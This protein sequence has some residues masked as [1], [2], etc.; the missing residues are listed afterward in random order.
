MQG[1]VDR[2][3]KSILREVKPLTLDE[4]APEEE[5]KAEKKKAAKKAL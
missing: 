1:V 2:I 4:V 5:P 3:N